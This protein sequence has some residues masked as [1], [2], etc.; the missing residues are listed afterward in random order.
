MREITLS[1]EEVQIVLNAL[2]NTQ[3]RVSYDALVV[4][5]NKLASNG[6]QQS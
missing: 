4:I 5:N 3:A 6:T 1:A 2:L